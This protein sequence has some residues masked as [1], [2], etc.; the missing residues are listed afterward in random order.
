MAYCVFR[1]RHQEGTRAVYNPENKKLEW[2]LTIA[3]AVGVI[4]MLTP[5]LFVWHQFVTVPSDAGEVEIV[6]R[7]WSWS[8]RLPGKD[9]KLGT[10]NVSNISPDNPLGINPD[11]PNGKDDVVIESDD[12]HLQ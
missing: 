4:A 10:S 11:D 2:W 3:T 7:Q 12:L 5:G 8:F 1:F 9:G 6:A